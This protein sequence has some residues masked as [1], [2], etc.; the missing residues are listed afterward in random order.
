MRTSQQWWDH[1]KTDKTLLDAWLR[2]QYI[3]ELAAVN[4]LS[5]VLI[6]FGSDATP[7]EWG[8]VHKVMCQEALHGKWMKELMDGRGVVPE[9]DASAERR[10]WAHVLPHVISFAEAM[11]AAFHAETMRLERIHVI[12]AEPDKAF[13]D[14]ASIFQHIL[15]HEEWHAKVFDEMRKGREMTR[16]HEKGLEALNLAMTA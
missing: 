13:Y 11:A 7:E 12:A 2:R 9:R 10:Y 5:E 15:P 14:I 4:L 8:T 16:Y 1:I 3:G 6:R